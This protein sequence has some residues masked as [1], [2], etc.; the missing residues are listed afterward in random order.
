[1]GNTC[2]F[3]RKVT[4]KFS[5]EHFIPD[6]LIGS[7]DAATTLTDAVCIKCNKYFGRTVDADFLNHDLIKLIRLRNHLF[8]PPEKVPSLI[9]RDT[10]HLIDEEGNV[11]K[12]D[13]VAD[14]KGSRYEPSLKPNIQTERN[15][16]TFI[17]S[18]REAYHLLEKMKGRKGIKV[19]LKPMMP[20]HILNMPIH[21]H[22]TSKLPLLNILYKMFLEFIYIEFGRKH[23]LE[24]KY[25]LL[26]EVVLGKDISLGDRYKWQLAIHFLYDKLIDDKKGIATVTH[27]IGIQPEQDFWCFYFCMFDDATFY[28]SI[29]DTTWY[30]SRIRTIHMENLS[31]KHK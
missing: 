19:I 7:A 4:E 23:C 20:K 8:L 31:L 30:K 14:A 24:D 6:K 22:I 5:R 1:M 25:D 13:S 15:K 21:L 17:R 29:P 27:T 11:Y 3:C 12:L 26:R 9:E 16:T 28:C 2:I 18:H 10:K